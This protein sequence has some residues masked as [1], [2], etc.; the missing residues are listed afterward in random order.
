M[1]RYL[2]RKSEPLRL[3]GSTIP[4]RL[5]VLYSMMC[6]WLP[7]LEI[8]L[9]KIQHITTNYADQNSVISNISALLVA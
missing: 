1:R 3:N 9:Y 4:Y 2:A 6:K 7:N 8:E 5:T